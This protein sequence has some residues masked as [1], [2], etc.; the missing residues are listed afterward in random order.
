MEERLIEILKRAGVTDTEMRR[1]IEL[2]KRGYERL[3]S[4]LGLSY[5]D[6]RNLLNRIQG[7]HE[8]TPIEDLVSPLVALE[9]SSRF[10][11]ESDILG[12]IVVNDIEAGIQ[13]LISGSKAHALLRRL[14]L[15]DNGSQAEQDILGELFVINESEVHDLEGSFAKEIENERGTY[16]FPWKIGNV[17][18][19]ATASYSGE[20]DKFSVGIVDIRD[21][22]GNSIYD[23]NIRPEVRRQA[24]AFIGKE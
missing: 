21:R 15:V 3:Q 6:V 12:N 11:Y 8:E 23:E 18:G 9:S 2:S 19:T 24:I 7:R 20:N 16:N 22:N 10:G 5:S 17:E 1:G 14:R 13:K 4:A